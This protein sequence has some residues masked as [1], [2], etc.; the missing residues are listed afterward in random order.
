[1][2]PRHVESRSKV[3]SQAVDSLFLWPDLGEIDRNHLSSEPQP[4]QIQQVFFW[5][6]LGPLHLL[7][8]LHTSVGRGDRDE[9]R[10]NNRIGLPRSLPMIH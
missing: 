4:H 9:R 8:V 7:E 2:R 5:R 10:S 3:G 1:M 6:L